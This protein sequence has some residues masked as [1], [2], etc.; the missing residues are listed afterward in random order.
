MITYEEIKAS[1]TISSYIRA[2]DSV[3]DALNYTE[4][5]FA[6]VGAVAHTAGYI[7]ETLGYPE[8]D[9]ELV[10][11]AAHMHDIGNMVNR[12]G[13][14][15]S[16][17]I[18][19]FQI[20]NGMGMPPEDIAAVVSAIGNHDEGTAEPISPIAAALIL[21]DKTDVRRSRVR[22]YSDVSEDDVHDRVNFAAEK[23]NVR[24]IS[25]GG[26]NIFELEMNLDKE[27]GS[28]MNFFEIYLSRMTLCRKACAALGMDFRTL[29][30]G[31]QITR[32]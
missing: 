17:A 27:Y 7:L 20:L 14:A 21:G 10:K 24:I 5:G 19:A 22:H 8:R 15:Q 16:G 23:T 3:L 26:R 2:A 31:Q 29:V 9:I 11:I 32:H 4:H 28:V 6:H 12:V 30:N 18:M 25:E 1:E 13:H